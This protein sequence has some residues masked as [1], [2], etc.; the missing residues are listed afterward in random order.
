MTTPQANLSN[1]QLILSVIVAALLGVGLT[2]LVILPAEKGEDPSG[3]GAVSG[4][5]QLSEQDKAREPIKAP[6]PVSPKRVDSPLYIRIDPATSKAIVNEFGEPQPFV[7]GANI[8]RHDQAYKAEL[9][10]IKIGPDEQ[11]EYKALMNE[12]EVLLYSWKAD[13]ELY[14]DF[15]AHQDSGD[16]NFFTRYAEGEGMADQGSIVAPYSGQHGWYWLNIAGKAVT[17]KLDVKGY[18]DEVIE[19]NLKAEAE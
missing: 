10:E 1:K 11:V 9:I 4:L 8:R 3:F 2:V 12:G 6:M 19:I 7:D 16:P 17:V 14:F 5:D 13:G 15:H 18:Y